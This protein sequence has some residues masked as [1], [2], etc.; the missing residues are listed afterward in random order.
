[1]IM[2]IPQLVLT[3]LAC[4]TFNDIINNY[5]AGNKNLF[6]KKFKNGL[7]AF[8]GL[9]GL[10]VVLYFTSG[11]YN[12]QDLSVLKQVK[13]LQPQ[14]KEPI[15]SF[16]TALKE[17]RQALMINSIIRSLVFISIAGGLIY[18]YTKGVIK[19]QLLTILLTLAVFVDAI[20][21]DTKYFNSENFQ[22]AEEYEAN[23]S[24]SPADQ[25]LLQDK[26]F[27]RV[28]NTTTSPFQ[29]A[30]TSYY[31]YSVGGYNPAK[32]SLYQDLIENQL[33]KSP[34]NMPVFN[35]L[36]TKYFITGSPASPQV[37]LNPGA[38]GQAWFVKT[39]KV[40]ADAAAEMKAL[41]NFNPKDTAIAQKQFVNTIKYNRNSADSN[42]SIQLVN[43][44]NDIVTYK[45]VNKNNGFGVFSEVY[46]DR[47]WLAFIDGKETAIAKVDYV[48]RGLSIPAGNHTIVFK[49]LPAAYKIG[50][51]TTS[52]F[53]V[54]LILI[55]L[56]A[57][58]MEYRKRRTG[59]TK[60][61][62]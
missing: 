48:L 35:M 24:P 7:I 2:V 4:L 59:F 30:K 37:Q 34:S 49:F 33:S 22:D 11:F 62:V 53:T 41:D 36:N 52:I 5:A 39:V 23:F 40:V 18:F 57:L 1:M 29:D 60:I 54:V 61:N 31:H 43:N 38:L 17:D 44:D 3:M 27:Y 20:T 58:F 15:M 42:A 46:Y 50:C 6:D 26:S 14:V 47:G 56:A 9:I 21:I 55:I 32:L 25:Q 28:F 12:E 8:G 19:K 13:D 16:F 51:L 45:S 10:T